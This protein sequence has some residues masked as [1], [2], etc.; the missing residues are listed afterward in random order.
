[1]NEKTIAMLHQLVTEQIVPGVSYALIQN[2]TVATDFFGQKQLVPEPRP[3]AGGELYDLASLTKVIGTTTVILQLLEANKLRL[4]DQVA[5]YLPRFTDPRVTIRHLLT[6]TSALSG[7]IKDRDQL[8]P[9][10][11]MAALYTLKPAV[12]LGKKVV[13]ADIGLILLGQI[14]EVFYHRP[15][16][17]VITTEVLRPLGMKESTF[18]PDKKRC[19]PTELS[20]TR[21]LIQGQVHDPKA[22]ILGEHCGSAGLF[23]PLADVVKFAQWMLQPQTLPGV[24]KPETVAMLYADHTPTGDL[25]RSLGWD[26][27]YD[28]K[29]T[30]CLYHTGFTGTFMLLDQQ[31]QNALIVLSNRIHPSVDNEAFLAW[32]DKIIATYLAEKD[33]V[34][35]VY[36]Q[37]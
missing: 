13:Y 21:G 17:Q 18:T 28:Q 4:D 30:P 29:Q 5:K 8:P 19:V 11:L 25:G 20:S 3:L 23:A 24:L 27:R 35:K 12:W 15:V 36:N 37:I 34:E 2:G 32:R 6:H 14:I 16:Q 33:Q 26:L 22:F 10:E 31:G 7:Y 1:M 9:A